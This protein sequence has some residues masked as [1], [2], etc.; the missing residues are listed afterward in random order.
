ML[1]GR[2]L[3]GGDYNPEQWLE[4]PEVL[5][6]D[7]RLMKEAGVNCVTLGVFSWSV[8]EPEEGVYNFDWLEE[9]ID[10]L[11]EEDI[12]VVLATPSGAMPHWLT[13]KYPEVRQVFAD[14]KRNLPG[15]RH[16]F[17]YTSPV[18]R[19]KITA[20][21]RAL[22]ERFGR[23]ENVILWHI[24]NELGG[25]FGDS[26]CHCELCQEAFREWLKKKYGTLD[27]L[28]HAWWGRFWSHVYTDWSQ[29][30]SPAPHGECGMTGLALDWKRFST[31][32]ISDFCTMEIEAVRT[33]S[34]LPVTANFMDFF[35]GLDYQ[36]MER[37]FDIISWDSYPFWHEK[38]DEVKPAVRAAANHSLMRA[39]KKQP[40]LLM[41]ST[42]SQ[43]SWRDY[44]PLKRPGMHMLSSIQAVAHGSDSV[45]YFQ[46]R[47]GR[48]SFE[49]FHGAVVD[50]LNGANTRTFHEVAEVGERLP[51]LTELLDKTVNR[52]KAAVIFDWENWWAVED[53]QGPRLDLDYV[54]CVLSHY[55]AF[56]E[57]GIE[58]DFIGMDADLDG[59]KL[60]SAPLNY[61]YKEGYAEKVRRFVESGGLYVTTYFSGVVDETD[62]CFTGHH[63]LEDVLGIMPEEIDAPS[64]EFANSFSYQGKEYPAMRICAV[65]HPKEGTEVLS[66]YDKDF[67][68]GAP[69]VTRNGYGGGQAFFIA[70]E[71]DISFLRAFYNDMFQSAGLKNAL[72]IE[73]PYGVT[74]TV[75]T[76]Q[77]D[78]AGQ[79]DKSLQMS[80]HCPAGSIVFV[81]NFRHEPVELTRIGE[82][83]D[84]ETKEKVSGIL[85]LEKLSCRILTAGL[86]QR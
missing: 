19:E 67:Y 84:A 52:P 66:V 29:I 16:N 33:Y 55:Q 27:N 38:Q 43:I 78:C 72:G 68:A 69:M 30:H 13:Q 75:R 32:Q 82:W 65:V 77:G 8:L 26:T 86:P 83:T 18:M 73:L 60:V 34:E 57:A 61:M 64:E 42:P 9:R 81:M 47:K 24:S 44:N 41:E 53:T 36:R 35:K 10:R 46:W 22:S 15:K 11:G 85:K 63:P 6:E 76:P 51:G 25:N 74:V 49:K 45:Q 54:E 23:K 1:G 14:G 71:S 37:D 39:L 79:N 2:L 28:N 50:H 62:L 20:L 58:A 17:C 4:C 80:G 56:W 5:E 70:A 40:F 59:Y 48:G 12:Q 3:H 7:I 31:E 21:D